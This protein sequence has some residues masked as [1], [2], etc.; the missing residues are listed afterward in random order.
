MSFC[1]IFCFPSF[2]YLL[3][4]CLIFSSLLSNILPV[5]S[6]LLSFW[7]IFC[8][9]SDHVS[10]VLLSIFCFLSVKYSAVLLVSD[11]KGLYQQACQEKWK[12]CKEEEE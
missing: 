3:T 7:P 4:L 12:K 8:Y 9:S 6:I 2:Q 11:G 5:L 1:K 10:A